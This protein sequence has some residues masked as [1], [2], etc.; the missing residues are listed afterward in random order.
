MGRV[1]HNG[2][3]HTSSSY[4][5]ADKIPHFRRG[6][7]KANFSQE[8]IAK[9]YKAAIDHA[10]S[11]EIG[12]YQTFFPGVTE[13]E[14]FIKKLRELFA[15]IGNLR[16]LSNASL[17]NDIVIRN[18]KQHFNYHIT[19]TP[20]ALRPMRIKINTD[21]VTLDTGELYLS[22]ADN[23][24]LKI[25]KQVINYV[26]K[27]PNEYKD[28]YDPFN[29]SHTYS[30]TGFK[31]SSDSTEA[32]DRWLNQE[33]QALAEK[34]EL[35]WTKLLMEGI[36]ITRD[37]QAGKTIEESGVEKIKGKD[38]PFS[39]FRSNQINDAIKAGD[40]EVI[41]AVDKA[42]QEVKDFLM[43]RINASSDSAL[44]KAFNL[45]WSKL[46]TDYFFEGKNIIK[47]VLGNPGEFA[48]D[49]AVNYVAFK[50]GKHNALLS[51]I[52]GDI[53]TGKRGQPR[54]DYELLAIIGHKPVSVGVQVKNVDKSG[55]D[56][57]EA[58]TDLGLMGPNLGQDMTTSIANYKF[59]ASIAAKLGDM[60]AE[61]GDYLENMIWNGLNF[62]I[63][64]G[65]IPEHTNTFYFL[66]G[67]MIIPVS[68]FILYLANPK[69]LNQIE[70]GAN[71]ITNDIMEAPETTISGLKPGQITDEKFNSGRPPLFLP[72]WHGKEPNWEPQPSNESE[73]QNLLGGIRVKT[74]LKFASF[75]DVSTRN[76]ALK[77]AAYYEIF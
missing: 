8:E 15:G 54:S 63:R 75:L 51:G 13:Y 38:L 22:T 12:V 9:D 69:G 57:I 3:L 35:I 48:L 16:G 26:K 71:Y 58:N 5:E 62:N 6:G 42:R 74:I 28:K 19:I 60:E 4:F 49:V 39:K 23:A 52:I 7:F 27:L 41:A 46:P 25:I 30:R 31:S 17:K 77:G 18:E 72:Y 56:D 44:Y 53:A 59:N 66:G 45:A 1:Y 36:T 65:L 40:T 2:L 10:R 55:Y 73:F 70:G 11:Q 24:E 32:L 67:S 20:E 34:D 68:R 29:R 14:V 76:T 64:D 21:V 33:L 50:T 61:L 37:P 47:G 43:K